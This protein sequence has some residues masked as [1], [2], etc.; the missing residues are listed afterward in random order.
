M[1]LKWRIVFHHHSLTCIGSKHLRDNRMEQYMSLKI[2]IIDDQQGYFVSLRKYLAQFD[3]NA[4]CFGNVKDAMHALASGE[5]GLLM[6]SVDLKEMNGFE[7][8]G[9]IKDQDHSRDIPIIFISEKPQPKDDIIAGLQIG[10]VDFMVKPFDIILL[11]LKVR[12]YLTFSYAMK[13]LVSNNLELTRLNKLLE[14]NIA[15]SNNLNTLLTKEKQRSDDLLLNI[16][17]AEVAEELKDKGSA[18]AKYFTDVSVLFTDFVGFTKAGEQF[19][20][21]EL[22][23][24]LDT[25][26]KAFDRIISKHGVEKI[27]T[28]GDSYMAVSGLPAANVNHAEQVVHAAIEIIGFMK[29]RKLELGDRTFEVRIGIH[30]GNVV[31]GIVGLKKFAYD[32]WGDAVNT[33]SRIEQHGE[34]NKINI[35]QSTFNLINTR[36]K[37]EH[38]GAIV[39]KNKGSL[40]MYFV[41]FES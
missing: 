22:V 27:K 17:P 18:A 24:E 3:F 26:F 23:N 30:S 12:N 10:G 37:C 34:P 36:F 2:L 13:M 4:D 14:E 19:S 8:A 21:Q 5:Y 6:I 25:C 16:L 15:Y 35:S 29:N 20:P 9:I 38:R 32:I 1:Q 11:M 31:A 39:A 28:I 33:A 41:D 7:L 40:D